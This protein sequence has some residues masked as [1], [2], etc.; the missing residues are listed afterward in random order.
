MKK[1]PPLQ[2][3][4]ITQLL[5][6]WSDGNQ[7]ALDRLYPLVYDELQRLARRYMSREK[8]VTHCKPRR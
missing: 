5:A 7:S 8:K 4:E 2:Q 1:G 6:E 3:H